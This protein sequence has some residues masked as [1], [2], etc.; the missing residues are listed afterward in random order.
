MAKGREEEAPFSLAAQLAARQLSQARLHYGDRLDA[1]LRLHGDEGGNTSVDALEI[2]IGDA[3]LLAD[4]PGDQGLRLRVRMDELDLTPWAEAALADGGDLT[5]PPLDRAHLIIGNLHWREHTLNDL[6]LRIGIQRDDGPEAWTG[7]IHSRR[8]S[9]RFRY[10]REPVHGPAT[11]ELE[12]L[13][14]RM[15][16]N[17]GAMDDDNATT[18]PRAPPAIDPRQLPGFLASAEDLLINDEP[19]GRVALRAER[20]PHGL[21]L[22]AMEIGNDR[23]RLSGTGHWYQQPDGKQ[24]SELAFDLASDSL[25]ELL[26]RLGL[27]EKLQGAP[28]RIAGRLSWPDGP[29]GAAD[30]E[31]AGTLSLAILQGSAPEMDPGLGRLFGL[32]NITALHRRLSFDFSDLFGEGFSFDRIEGEVRFGDGEAKSDN[33][34]I[35]GPAARIE[36]TGSADLRDRTLDQ[37]ITVSGKVSSA[38]PIAGTLTGGPA[39]GAALLIAQQLLGDKMD[40]ISAAEYQISGP[41]DDPAVERINKGGD[42]DG[43]QP[44]RNTPPRP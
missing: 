31:M 22:T 1:A 21:D 34:L 43:A 40:R 39:V 11:I 12:R 3:D 27:A 2:A 19:M 26:I 36:I 41:W 42:E 30:E 13:A 16:R 5:L 18:P 25:G 4:A 9:G 24:Q 8:I 33:L 29:F 15:G 14:L 28:A 38:L 37:R 7:D 23:H 17:D 10:P 20:S 35:E 44:N 6:A 32:L